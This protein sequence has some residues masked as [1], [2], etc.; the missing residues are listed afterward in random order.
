MLTWLT[1]AQ[2]CFTI[3]GCLVA[4]PTLGYSCVPARPSVAR[5]TR[6]ELLQ[7]G[8]LAPS[9]PGLLWPNSTCCTPG[10]PCNHSAGEPINSGWISNG[11]YCF[12]LIVC[13][14]KPILVYTYL[15]FWDHDGLQH[16]DCKDFETSN[17]LLSTREYKCRHA[18]ET[19]KFL[20]LSHSLAVSKMAGDKVILNISS[21][22]QV[23]PWW[24]FLGG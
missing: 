17:S 19:S 8:R 2:R 5:W 22:R 20:F 4:S 14:Y 1:G 16:I 7:A 3:G 13:V 23:L 21:L 9:Q 6:L 24:V 18:S 12:V 10:H 11:I 15:F